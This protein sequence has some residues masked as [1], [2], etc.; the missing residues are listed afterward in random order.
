MRAKGC[1]EA[2]AEQLSSRCL[3]PPPSLA[4][5]RQ[6]SIRC[7]KAEVWLFRNIL[8]Y[9]EVLRR[10]W[11]QFLCFSGNLGLVWGLERLC[12]PPY[13][14]KNLDMVDAGGQPSEE[15]CKICIR[16]N[17]TCGSFRPGLVCD[18]LAQIPCSSA[19]SL[20]TTP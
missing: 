8:K 20:T 10:I 3:S 15:T 4:D 11:G 5:F 17:A 18:S 6:I 9:W 14:F 7:L 16:T 13:L 19:H 12:K 1:P 2:K